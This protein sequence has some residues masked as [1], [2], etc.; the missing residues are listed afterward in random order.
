MKRSSNTKNNFLLEVR[1]CMLF[2]SFCGIA[3]Q[4]L[5]K[6]LIIKFSQFSFCNFLP[7]KMDIYQISPTND[8]ILDDKIL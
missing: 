5:Q 6:L 8:K 7:N 3:I 4:L 2:F 1:A